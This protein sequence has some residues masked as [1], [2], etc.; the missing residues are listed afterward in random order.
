MESDNNW[1]RG[2]IIDIDKTDGDSPDN[3]KYL[4]TFNFYPANDDRWAFANELLDD[5]I[6]GD[7]ISET[8]G[9]GI[10]FLDRRSFYNFGE[11]KSAQ[12]KRLI[13]VRQC[14]LCQKFFRFIDAHEKREHGLGQR[15]K[16]RNVEFN[17]AP[18]I[19]VTD[20]NDGE[21]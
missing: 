16:R 9:Y 18:Q 1:H 13:V 21:I 6:C 20:E 10:I 19:R 15:K 8:I 7:Q 11:M 5:T 17:D 2:K 14:M 12:I 3:L 4:I